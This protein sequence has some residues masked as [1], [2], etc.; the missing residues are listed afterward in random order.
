[1][2]VYYEFK[3]L[4]DK[5]TPLKSETLNKIQTDIKNDIS[6]INNNI[7]GITNMVISMNRSKADIDSV[8]TKQE[9]DNKYANAI[10][11]ELVKVKEAQIYSTGVNLQNVEIFGES[12]Q[13]TREGYN[14]LKYPYASTF[15]DTI[16]TDNRDG[17]ITLNGNLE[18]N[19]SKYFVRNYFVKAGTYTFVTGLGKNINLPNTCYFLIKKSTETGYI[20][21]G[22]RKDTEF[23]LDADS[24]ID[25][26]MIFISGNYNNVLLKP[27][28]I[29][30]TEEKPYEQ[31]GESPNIDYPS[32]INSI[33]ENINYTCS[34]GNSNINTIIEL[35]EGVELC[36]LSNGVEDYIDSTGIIHKNIKSYILTGNENWA[37]S[38]FSTEEFSVFYS[39]DA[40]KSIEGSFIL[41]TNFKVVNGI[42][43]SVPTQEG[44]SYTTQNLG[45]RVSIN[46][47]K[48]STL[49]E[50]KELL[51]TNNIKIYYACTDEEKTTQSLANTEKAKLQNLQTFEGMNNI[52][53]NATISA[54]YNTDTKNYIDSKFNALAEQV[55]N[56]V[57]GN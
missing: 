10:K 36:G 23:T 8:Y 47:S 35:P 16:F 2:N 55:L 25:I 34:N 37:K 21:Q 29:L 7:D 40:I 19:T 1:M 49:E 6:N 44:I 18:S 52:T 46:S 11:Q 5:T 20:V 13:E 26:S 12:T 27:M 3:D 31:Y 51:R 57:G 38:E 53:T 30:G 28:L 17:T 43:N 32:P 54:V 41:C 39:T 9:S 45:L 56:I 33:V 50:F 14:L 22:A 24:N 48:A 15:T 42:G 4:P